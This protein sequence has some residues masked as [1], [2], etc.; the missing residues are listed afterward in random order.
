MKKRNTQRAEHA[1]KAS[2]NAQLATMLGS[3]AFTPVM[4]MI[5]AVATRAAVSAVEEVVCKGRRLHVAT[6][7][8]LTLPGVPAERA[9]IGS[10]ARALIKE[11][12]TD[13]E[14]WAALKAQF[15]HLRRIKPYAVW[16]RWDAVRKGI[17]SKGFAEEHR[18]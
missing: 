7:G 4:D 6:R 14:V 8:Q 5:V 1:D 3:E 12:K 16:Y 15:P 11:G 9:T 2:L 18:G 10:F 17:V 13:E